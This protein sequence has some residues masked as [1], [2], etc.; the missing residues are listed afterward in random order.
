MAKAEATAQ[1]LIS[2]I[3]RGEQ[4]CQKKSIRLLLHSSLIRDLCITIA[5]H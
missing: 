5:D 2:K 1:E 4:M 3:E